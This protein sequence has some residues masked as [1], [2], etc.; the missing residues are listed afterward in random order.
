MLASFVDGLS[1]PF[2]SVGRRTLTI[3]R[4]LVVNQPDW[5]LWVRRDTPQ[6][7]TERVAVSSDVS[8]V[9]AEGS[10]RGWQSDLPDSIPKDGRITKRAVKIDVCASVQ[11][12]S[13]PF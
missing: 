10:R 3:S 9:V 2:F 8:V 11:R 7:D 13:S 6:V 1:I 12:V 5:L 4:S